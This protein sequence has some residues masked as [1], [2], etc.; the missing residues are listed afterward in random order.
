MKIFLMTLGIA[1]SFGTI[2]GIYFVPIAQLPPFFFVLYPVGWGVT[3]IG[4]HY[5]R[6]TK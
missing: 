1:I 5:E 2:L 4:L 6:K 3:F